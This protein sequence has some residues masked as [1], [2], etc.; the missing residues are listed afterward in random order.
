[1]PPYPRSELEEMMQRWLKANEL[2]EREGDW[3]KHLSQFY[4]QDAEYRWNMGPKQEC[5]FRGRDQIRDIALGYHM[6]GF[7]QWKYPYHTV[8]I[9]DQRGT[10]I[11]LYDQISPTGVAVAGIS[12]SWLEYGGNFQWRWQR[13]FFDLGNVKT[14]MFQMAGENQLEPIVQQK[15]QQQARG[16]LLPGIERIS[17]ERSV[18]AKV[19]DFLA[20]LKIVIFGG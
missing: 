13:D 10:V 5:V 9:D 15:I 17:Q 18:C 14:I 8:I 20:M 12:G 1:M 2:A 7:E 11:G 3:S 4:Q 16:T 6:K 19:H